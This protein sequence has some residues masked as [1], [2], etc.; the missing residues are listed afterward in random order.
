MGQFIL[1][2]YSIPRIDSFSFTAA[3]NVFVLQNWL[4]EII[5]Y[6]LYVIGGETILILFNTF[7]FAAVLFILYRISLNLSHCIWA[8]LFSSIIAAACL[9]VNIR[10]QV[11]SF[12]F[13][14]LF[15]WI[16]SSFKPGSSRRLYWL[17]ALMMVWANIHGAFVLGLGLIAIVLFVEGIKLRLKAMTSEIAGRSSFMQLAAVFVLSLAAPLANPESHLIYH[18]VIAVVKASSVRLFVSEWQPPQIMEPAA[19][20]LFFFP[21]FTTLLVLILSEES[22]RLIDWLLFVV[23]AIFGLTAMRSCA[24][25]QL[26][27]MPILARHL[28][29]VPWKSMTGLWRPNF[30]RKAW[31]DF[32]VDSGRLGRINFAIA[33]LL[34]LLVLVK[35]PWWRNLQGEDLLDGQTPV[36]AADYIEEQN[37]KGNIFHPQIYG[38]YLLWRLWPQQRVFFDGRVH[39]YGEEFVRAYFRIYEDSDWEDRLKKFK[40]RY[41]LLEKP[42]ETDEGKGLVGRIGR[43]PNWK[44]IFEDSRSILWERLTQND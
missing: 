18:H 35:S 25:F 37:L 38:D 11:F 36:G 27:A 9:P 40:I 44:K 3:G 32:S 14:V 42:Q 39:L 2:N 12:L 15:Y 22:P 19:I 1:H 20:L 17:P 34:V 23:F 21:F 41:V 7:I 43:S 13:F 8:S 29:L 28:P 5:F 24:W 26:I 16:L 4:A 6:A 33:G 30:F 31:L 10:P